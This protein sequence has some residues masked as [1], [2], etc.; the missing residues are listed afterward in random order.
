VEHTI[1]ERGNR[2][3]ET[4]E[5]TRSSDVKECASGA[6]RGTNKNERSKSAHERR[7]GNEKRVAGANVMMTT[8]KEMAELMREQ[9]GEQ[10]EGERQA[11]GKSWWVFVKKGEGAQKLIERNGLILRVGEGE[12]GAGNEAGAKSEE[13]KNTGKIKR[14]KRRARR[15]SRRWLA[16]R[17]GAPIQVDRNG[18]WR[19]FLGW[20]AHEMF[21]ECN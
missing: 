5:R 8:G 20:R 16:I 21:C 18:W 19:I 3:N 14:F 11:G 2:Q 7:K 9:D 15:N 1:G 6:N 12:L 10:S 4:Y 17:I 13:K